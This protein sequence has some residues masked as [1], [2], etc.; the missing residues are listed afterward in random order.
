[1]TWMQF[2]GQRTCDQ[3]SLII[4]SLTLPVGV[5]R[6]R[7]D[8]VAAECLRFAS[9]NFRKSRGKPIA[10][11]GNFFELKQQY[12]FLQRLVV[13]AKTSRDLK[14]I[15]L[16]AAQAAMCLRCRA[17]F[18]LFSSVGD[19]GAR[20]K[21]SPA[22]LADRFRNRLKGREASLAN[23]DAARR[24]QGCGANP[25]RRRKQNCGKRIDG[26]AEYHACGIL[27]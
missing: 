2:S 23:R 9:Y 3:L 20:Q 17:K 5:Q 13:S 21:R 10:E 19:L 8:D 18:Q 1:M 4:A 7:Y 24:E 26:G 16:I 6:H 14:S 27:V 15:K 12:G 22:A 11:A 25:A